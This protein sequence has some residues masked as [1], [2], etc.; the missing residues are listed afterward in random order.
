MT[1]SVIASVSVSVRGGKSKPGGAR[2]TL[3]I[4]FN[5]DTMRLVEDKL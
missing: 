5:T 4:C 2:E 3:D 1:T